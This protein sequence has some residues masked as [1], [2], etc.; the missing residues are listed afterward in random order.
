MLT[1]E[2]RLTSPTLP[3]RAVEDCIKDDTGA[4][5]SDAQALRNDVATIQVN[6]EEILAR[7]ASLRNGFRGGDGGWTRQW[8]ESMGVL[9]SYAES[10]YQETIID[11]GE[12]REANSGTVG[13]DVETLRGNHA[14]LDPISELNPLGEEDWAVRT[15]HGSGPDD[16]DGGQQDTRAKVPASMDDIPANKDPR[17]TSSIRNKST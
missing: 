7:V 3:T 10:T 15:G 14:H 9:S 16:E 13:G 11:T 5:R 6:T 4:I 8:V 2:Y 17:K 1:A 12:E